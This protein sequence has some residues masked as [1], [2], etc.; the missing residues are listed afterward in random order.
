MNNHS[1]LRD[2]TEQLSM[3]SK[4]NLCLEYFFPLGKYLNH[5]VLL[6]ISM[7]R[8]QVLAKNQQTQVSYLQSKNKNLI[9]IAVKCKKSLDSCISTKA[10]VFKILV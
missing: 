3:Q 10:K 8:K 7:S 5:R 1:V 6:V 4:C 9:L 2:L